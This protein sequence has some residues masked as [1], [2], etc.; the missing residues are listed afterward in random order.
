M[1]QTQKYQQI[2][3]DE[4]TDEPWPR[5]PAPVEH[6]NITPTRVDDG[7]ALVDILNDPNIANWLAA[8]PQAYTLSDAEVNS[9]HYGGRRKVAE[10]TEEPGIKYVRVGY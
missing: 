5:L 1:A 4:T 9:V 10:R 2:H 3:F 7:L 8:I 6:Y